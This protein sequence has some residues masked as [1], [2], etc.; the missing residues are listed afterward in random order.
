[1]RKN[2][3]YLSLGANSIAPIYRE[4]SLRRGVQSKN[5]LMK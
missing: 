1:M 4:L 2:V 3:D 5:Q